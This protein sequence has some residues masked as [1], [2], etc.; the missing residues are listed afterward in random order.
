MKNY[1]GWK[2]LKGQNQILGISCESSWK[3]FSLTCSALKK[4]VTYTVD[5]KLGILYFQ[6]PKIINS[7][8]LTYKSF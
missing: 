3:C 5:I 8:G 4:N 6:R 2:E 1:P 7:D